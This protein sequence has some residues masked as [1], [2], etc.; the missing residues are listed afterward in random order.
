MA[1]AIVRPN[2]SIDE[3]DSLYHLE[4]RQTKQKLIFQELLLLS[5]EEPISSEK[6]WRL[7]S[8]FAKCHP[9]LSVLSAAQNGKNYCRVLEYPF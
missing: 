2:E 8:P 7:K 9:Q 6:V 3:H 5:Q 1:K 4:Y